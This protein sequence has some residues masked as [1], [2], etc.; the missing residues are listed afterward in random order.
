MA[1][2]TGKSFKVDLLIVFNI[3]YN[4]FLA[5]EMDDGIGTVGFVIIGIAIAAAL[6]LLMLVVGAYLRRRL[7]NKSNGIISRHDDSFEV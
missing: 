5:D 1:Y 7:H 3:V 6:F 2:T 4:L